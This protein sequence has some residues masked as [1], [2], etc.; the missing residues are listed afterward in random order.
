MRKDGQEVF[1]FLT[2][3]P[4]GCP[5]TTVNNYHSS[6]PNAAEKH[7]AHLHRGESLITGM[8]Q[9]DTCMLTE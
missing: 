5:E 1:D 6:L 9:I 7:R 4:I 3:G 8:F 2:L